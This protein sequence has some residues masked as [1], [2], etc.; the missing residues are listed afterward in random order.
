MFSQ[1]CL[2]ANKPVLVPNQAIA[3]L[4]CSLPKFF[5]LVQDKGAV[6]SFAGCQSQNIQMIALVF[7]FIEATPGLLFIMCELCL[8]PT[9]AVNTC[10][11]SL[12]ARCSLQAHLH[13]SVSATR[14]Q[15]VHFV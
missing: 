1:A 3:C 6:F 2:H 13:V 5:D 4:V 9:H 14:S 15:A 7:A 10:S 8:L 12:P 11:L